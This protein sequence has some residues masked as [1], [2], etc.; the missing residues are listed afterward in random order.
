MRRL[1]LVAILL[2]SLLIFDAGAEGI[3]LTSSVFE[4]L[5]SGDYLKEISIAKLV[6]FEEDE[7]CL[8]AKIF[9]LSNTEEF[10]ELEGVG[11]AQTLENMKKQQ[12]IRDMTL[13]VV[14]L[15]DLEFAKKG[16]Q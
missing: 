2:F 3:P 6:D 13:F 4:R 14:D 5:R 12:K 8:I 10:S 11:D 7:A 15:C 9:L 16:D 1:D